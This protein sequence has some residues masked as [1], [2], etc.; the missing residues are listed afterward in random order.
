MRRK[1]SVRRRKEFV[2]RC[3]D[4]GCDRPVRRPA[5]GTGGTNDSISPRDIERERLGPRRSRL[6]RQRSPKLDLGLE[7]GGDE[8]PKWEYGQEA[9]RDGC[10][11]DN[12]EGRT[13]A[14]RSN[15][16]RPPRP[17]HLRLRQR[18][19]EPKRVLRRV[20]EEL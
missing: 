1:E 12:G 13:L 5:I 14:V 16:R 4:T 3:S 11:G 20:R 2:R 18:E 7:R 9:R 15:R 6:R 19:Q 8:A 10:H 17:G